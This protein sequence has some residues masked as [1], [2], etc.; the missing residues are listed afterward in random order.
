MGT[1]LSVESAFDKNNGCTLWPNRRISSN[2]SFKK[3]VLSDLIT[4]FLTY[5]VCVH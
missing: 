1:V 2:L 3:E 5:I 4:L